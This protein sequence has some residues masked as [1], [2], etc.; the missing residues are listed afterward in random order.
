MAQNDYLET[1][2]QPFPKR[3]KTQFCIALHFRN[4]IQ[5]NFSLTLF[6]N[7]VAEMNSTC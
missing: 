6:K 5:N 4:S 3:K 1:A 2:A 7:D